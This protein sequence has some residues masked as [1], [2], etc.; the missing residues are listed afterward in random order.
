MKHFSRLKKIFC[1]CVIFSVLVSLSFAD[2]IE[3][4]QGNFVLKLLEDIG[5]FS[6]SHYSSDG[7]QTNFFVPYDSFESTHFVA[8]VGKK[9]YPLNKTSFGKYSIYDTE[10]GGGI[11]Y[12]LGKE[13]E[14]YINYTFCPGFS[15]NS[16]G[17]MEIDITVQNIS[18]EIKT[19]ELKSIFDTVLGENSGVH[20][21]TFKNN[22]IE[23]E[24]VLEDMSVEKWVRSTNG[25]LSMQFLLHGPGITTP[26][27]VVLANK[28]IL[29]GSNWN[30][31]VV[32]GR[33]FN[34]VFSYNNSAIGIFWNPM[35]LEPMTKSSIKFYITYSADRQIPSDTRFLSEEKE[36]HLNS[37]DEVVYW[38][39]FGTMYTL[40]ALSEAQLDP[41]Y[42]EELLDRIKQL[43]ANPEYVDRMEILRLNAEL[44]AI[45]EKIRRL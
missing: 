43:E 15:G 23:T 18:G 33:S 6:L 21:L 12:E 19:V 8:K 11:K 29:L 30:P 3:K 27:S 13:V 36:S 35:I 10:N 31:K 40:G 28:D 17:A 1:L 4:N 24:T 26:T 42:I 9:I 44:D 2:S 45:L 34:S 5:S 25:N 39:E 14:I 20:F 32:P 22:F 16:Q 38:D 7:K 41:K 37:L